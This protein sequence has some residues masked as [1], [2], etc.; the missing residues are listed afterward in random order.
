MASV[1]KGWPDNIDSP[2]A[3]A[4]IKTAEYVWPLC[5]NVVVLRCGPGKTWLA[6]HSW[7]GSKPLSRT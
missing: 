5:E 2:Q 1:R 6:L 7:Y 3:D 4:A